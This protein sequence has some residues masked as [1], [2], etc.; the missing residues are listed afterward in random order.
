MDIFSNWETSGAVV[1]LN[2]QAAGAAGAEYWVE[3][4]KF[5]G[6]DYFY[7]AETEKKTISGT[8]ASWSKLKWVDGLNLVDGKLN[9]AA[10]DDILLLACHAGGTS[11]VRFGLA[12]STYEGS[13]LGYLG[14]GTAFQ[15]T[16]PS[17]VMVRLTDDPTLNVNEINGMSNFSVYPNPASD[18]INVTLNKEVSATITVL[19]VTGKVV[20]TSTINGTTTS[21][22]TTGLSNGV[23]YVNITDG[24]SVSTEKV[25]IKK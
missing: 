8:A 21:I 16:S 19:D 10:G 24:T 14:N 25:V 6:T 15:L 7:E 5:D 2:T 13:V 4:Y 18:V 3:V 11:E 1:R 17:A 12:Q 22:N 20:K 9:F 23:Y